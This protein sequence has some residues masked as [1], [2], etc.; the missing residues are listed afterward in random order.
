MTSGRASERL[1]LRIS[2]PIGPHR[3]WNV[4]IAQP[5]T[6]PPAAPAAPAAGRPPRSTTPRATS[7]SPR[8]AR[9]WRSRSPPTGSPATRG[10]RAPALAV[11]SPPRAERPV[12]I[13]RARTPGGVPQG[14]QGA[15]QHP[16]QH[17]ARTGEDARARPPV[18][19]GRTRDAGRPHRPRAQAARAQRRRAD[20]AVRRAPGR[21]TFSSNS[22]PARSPASTTPTAWA[23]CSSPYSPLPGR[24]S[25]TTSEKTLEGQVVATSKGNHGGRPKLVDDDMLT[26]AV[27]LRDQ[28]VPVPDIAQKLT[29]KTGKNAGKSPSADSRYRALAEADAVAADDGLPLYPKP[30]RIRRPEDRSPLRRST[31]AS[32]SRRSPTRTRKYG[33]ADPRPRIRGRASA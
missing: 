30:A 2:R 28:G 20:G 21:R 18:Q 32:G 13:G 3:R 31:C 11:V 17:Q 5:V 10:S 26:F 7:S 1:P 23:P 8:S 25:A 9:N 27:A 19:G 22:S 6:R 33:R 4:T 24:S 15:D 16:R 12:R 29:I 14:L